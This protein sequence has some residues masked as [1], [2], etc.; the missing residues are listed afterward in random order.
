MSYRIQNNPSALYQVDLRTGSA[1][2][3]LNAAELGNRNLTGLGYNPLDNFLYASVSG[4]NDIVRIGSSGA[5]TLINVPAL[6]AAVY[7]A[8]DAGPDGNLYLYV[9]GTLAMQKVNLA[10]LAVT[11]IN[12]G[13]GSALSDFS[14]SADGNSIYGISTNTGDLVRYATTGGTPTTTNVGFGGFY[15]SAYLDNTG[16]LYVIEDA[17]SFVFEVVGPTIPT[18]KSAVLRTTTFTPITNTDGAR[19]VTSSATLQTPLTCTAG[20]AF[21]VTGEQGYSTGECTE[22]GNSILAEYN[23]QTGA[24]IA[25]TDELINSFNARTTI[26]NL[27]YNVT[28]NYLWGYRNGTNQLIRIGSEKTVD[29]FAISGLSSDCSYSFG[30]INNT[31]FKAGDIS[32]NGILYLLNGFDGD[33]FIR[34]DVNPSSPTYLQKLSDI[35]LSLSPGAGTLAIM[36]DLA[37][38]PIDGNLYG[39][40]TDKNLVRINPTT[41]VVSV[42]GALA[43]LEDDS[44]NFLIAFFDQAGSLYVQQSN[45][46]VYKIS[47]VAG[48]NLIATIHIANGLNVGLNGDGAS[49]P[50]NA[51][52]SYSISGKLLNDANGLVDGTVNG[53]TVSSLSGN[54][55]SANLVGSAGTVVATTPLVSGT[56]TFTGLSANSSYSVVLSNTPGTPG[57][58]PPNTTLVGGVVN[59]GEYIGTGVGS[60]GLPDGVLSI[61]VATSQVVDANFGIERLPT[62]NPKT[63]VNQSNPGGT[64]TINVPTLTGSDPEDGDYIGSTFNNMIVIQQL[65]TNAT[66]YYDGILVTEGQVIPNYEPDLLTLDPIDGPVSVTF[67]YSERDAAGLDS[68]PAQVSISFIVLPDLSLLM[69]ARPT[70]VYGTA[71]VTVVVDVVELNS[72]P[73]TGLIT[74]KITR[75]AKYSL[76]FPSSAT[77]VGSRTVQNSLWQF[78]GSDPSYYVLTTN[79][80]VPAGDRLSVGLTGVLTAGATSGSIAVS[81][82]LVG[83]SGSESRVTNNADADKIDYFQQ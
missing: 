24:L 63:L 46:V 25:Q 39:V 61:S 17:N 54:T 74:L 37:F 70:S 32:L 27:G 33:R 31:V 7:T 4:T 40:G 10:T 64:A 34:V 11:S 12:L 13:A 23:L 29:F 71:P 19:C 45:A 77:S 62:A 73:T 76:T 41:G 57:A 66:L 21:V 3:L 9:T 82:V 58:A 55:F 52:L 81:S 79:S 16:N 14:V 47:N 78:N 8:G 59:T 30:T 1:T 68:P 83:V 50:F 56:Y 53:N 22:A 2:L 67:T 69:Y 75:D 44:S 65:P 18:E 5:V 43:G 6:P 42:L 36:A 49:C 28:D 48:N 72:V 15:N 60:D 51:Q 35:P 80:A 20:Q 38:N 26:N